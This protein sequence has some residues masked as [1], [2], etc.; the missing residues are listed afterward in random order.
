MGI[1][2]SKCPSMRRSSSGTANRRSKCH[3]P[4]KPQQW[5]PPRQPNGQFAPWAPENSPPMAYQNPL[6]PPTAHQPPQGFK[7]DG[8]FEDPDVVKSQLEAMNNYHAQQ[9]QQ[10]QQLLMQQQQ[11]AEQR[12]WEQQQAWQAASREASVEY[13]RDVMQG[14]GDDPTVLQDQRTVDTLM[15][16]IDSL[17]ANQQGLSYEAAADMA[18]RL[19]P[20]T[21]GQSR[22]INQLSRNM[23]LKQSRAIRRPNTVGTKRLGRQLSHEEQ[24][25]GMTE[26]E[27]VASEE[28]WNSYGRRK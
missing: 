14:R 10:M 23:R 26:Q 8:D 5:Q 13:L 7:V 16:T 27:A 12:Y 22:T 6:Q 9:M 24:N 15:S 11:L 25:L 3:H 19:L 28:L 1:R 4:S 2:R 20:Q 17:R 21:N 18:L